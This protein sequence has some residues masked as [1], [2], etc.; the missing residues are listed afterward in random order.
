MMTGTR[1]KILSSRNWDG[2]ISCL[3]EIFK[4]IWDIKNQR[5]LLFVVLCCFLLF[6]V[7]FGSLR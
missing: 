7:I 4:K 2:S 5:L 6:F 1:Q 3:S